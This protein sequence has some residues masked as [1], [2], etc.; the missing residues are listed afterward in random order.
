MFM[1][2]CAGLFLLAE[3]IKCN[4]DQN[5][6]FKNEGTITTKEQF[7]RYCHVEKHI[8]LL[9]F[10]AAT[11]LMLCEYQFRGCNKKAI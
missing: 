3:Y 7:P 6:L 10:R 9:Q 4:C 1:E 11:V 5:F 8:H 2:Q